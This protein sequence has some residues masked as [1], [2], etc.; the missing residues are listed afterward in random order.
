M[1]VLWLSLH[2]AGK[3]FIYFGI[4]LLIILSGFA[5]AAQFAYGSSIKKYNTWE[6]Q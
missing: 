1:S 5:V 6:N 2:D 4:A 3:N